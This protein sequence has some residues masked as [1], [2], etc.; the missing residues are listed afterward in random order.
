MQ[1]KPIGLPLRAGMISAMDPVPTPP[2][3]RPRGVLESKVTIEIKVV[4]EQHGARVIVRPVKPRPPGSRDHSRSRVH[5]RA[6][7][8]TETGEWDPPVTSSTLSEA[9]TVRIT[10]V[11][12]DKEAPSASRI[13]KSPWSR[14]A[15]ALDRALAFYEAGGC[16]GL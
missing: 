2:S 12:A 3:L 1:L 6:P 15:R 10:A 16:D 5:G 13:E 14:V 7:S 9:P 8:A 4:G 11:A